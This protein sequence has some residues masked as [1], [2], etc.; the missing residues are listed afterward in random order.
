MKEISLSEKGKAIIVSDVHLGFDNSN[1]DDFSQF[2][3]SLL[4]TKSEDSHL[5]INGDFVDFWR[6]EPL[7]V[8]LRAIEF[9]T[10]NLKPLKENGWNIYYVVGN[11]DYCLKNIADSKNLFDVLAQHFDVEIVYP[12]LLINACPERSR[13]NFKTKKVLV[14]HG[15]IVDF[16]Y[17]FDA[18]SNQNFPELPFTILDDIIRNLSRQ[19]VYKFYDWIYRQDETTITEYETFFSQKPA[20]IA[21]LIF[22]F[23]R[24]P[25]VQQI[26]DREDEK[27]PLKIFGNVKVKV[28]SFSVWRNEM[29]LSK[30]IMTQIITDILANK[31]IIDLDLKEIYGHLGKALKEKWVPIKNEK[32]DRIVVGHFHEPRPHRKAKRIKDRDLNSTVFDDGSWVKSSEIY[33]T[34][35]KIFDDKISLNQFIS[36]SKEKILSKVVV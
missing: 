33:N 18:I 16:M 1:E 4:K 8:Y 13:R 32:F 6:A 30:D 24:S 5:I 35:V 31:E 20:T 27:V 15:D 7:E 22:N 26:A 28:D 14:T 12:A 36:G 17:T 19:D 23:L 34:Y 9:T 11:H 10:N 2:L 21:K 3:K 25:L 29:N